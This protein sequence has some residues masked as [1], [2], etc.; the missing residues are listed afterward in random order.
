L[1]NNT[2]QVLAGQYL[3][4]VRDLL[5]SVDLISAGYRHS[6]RFTDE[7]PLTAV[8]PAWAKSVI[9]ADMVREI[10]HN[11]GGTIDALAITD[12]QIEDWF[13]ARNVNVIWTL[14]G[15][16]AGTYGTGG[17]AITDQWFPVATAGET[18]QWPG[19]VSSAA[20]QLAWFLYVEGTFQFLDGGRLDLGV[21]R[22]SLL[23]STND[24]ETFTEVFESLAFRGVE[25]LQVQS[26]I[27]PSGASAGTIAPSGYVE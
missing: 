25:A 22:D 17:H 26:T 6:H 14:D 4:A 8:F 7:A 20:F 5:S 12:E 3:G 19:Q 15:L 27:L 21:V 1:A 9:R 10:A 2:K 13:S 24:Y 16:K 11:N 18:P 23:D